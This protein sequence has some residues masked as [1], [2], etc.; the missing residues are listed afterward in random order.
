MIPPQMPA[1]GTALS[2]PALKREIKR[3]ERIN[4]SNCIFER[5]RND[6]DVRTKQGADNADEKNG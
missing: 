6:R 2:L 3:Q 5:I 1:L 4:D